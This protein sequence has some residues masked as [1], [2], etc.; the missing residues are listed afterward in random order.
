MKA[1]VLASAAIVCL[2]V[3]ASAQ[4]ERRSP[5]TDIS[6]FGGRFD[7]DELEIE[8]DGDS[9]FDFEAE[10]ERDRAGVRFAFGGDSVRGFVQVFGEELSG[11]F[12][13]DEEFEAFGLG[14]GVRG[15]ARMNAAEDPV[16][17]GVPF[18][19]SLAIVAGEDE[20]LGVDETLAYLEFQGSVGFGL[21]WMGLRPSAGFQVSSVGGIDVVEADVDMDGDDD[22]YLITGT[23]FGPYA[24]LA[25]KHPDAPLYVR[26]RAGGGDFES[27]E[28]A[29]G[30][31]W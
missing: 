22:E 2:A 5:R 10:V 18:L 24:E 28:L 1:T 14:G 19:A 11:E 23:N 26:F 21:D 27:A 12:W 29:V 7:L 13:D 9:S 8:L 4:E 17:F 30:F 6:F 20:P 3:A 25:Y 15:F 31:V 16:A